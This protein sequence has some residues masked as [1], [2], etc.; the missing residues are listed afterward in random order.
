MTIGRII[1]FIVGTILV[2]VGTSL[3]NFAVKKAEEKIKTMKEKKEA[4]L[5]PQFVNG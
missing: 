2:G 4:E 5:S 1:G 3:G